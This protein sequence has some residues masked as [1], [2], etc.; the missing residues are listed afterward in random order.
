MTEEAQ[1][2]TMLSTYVID[3]VAPAA[4][5]PVTLTVYELMQIGLEVNTENC[6][7]AAVKIMQLESRALL[8][9]SVEV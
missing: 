5:V 4:R 9:E 7:L 6:L 8:S 3:K 2:L 1:G